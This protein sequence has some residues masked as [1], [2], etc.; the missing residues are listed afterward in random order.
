MTLRSTV[1]VSAQAGAAAG[2][3]KTETA[4]RTTPASRVRAAAPTRPVASRDEAIGRAPTT[5]GQLLQVGAEACT[6]ATAY[7]LL[8][9]PSQSWVPAGGFVPQHPAG[10]RGGGVRREHR[11]HLPTELA[12]VL[13]SQTRVAAVADATVV[14]AYGSAPQPATT[15]YS[16]VVPQ[17]VCAFGQ[18]LKVV[19][20]HPSLG[21]WV[22]DSAPAMTWREGHQW[23]LDVELPSEAFEFKVRRARRSTVARHF[24]AT[25]HQQQ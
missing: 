19:G 17:Y 6:H 1:S 13:L 11:T 9:M 8:G 15:R 7:M 21:S 23:F 14:T 20:S 2:K 10:K 5:R 4:V 12:C 22:A 3:P 16:I 25:D 24:P 18:Y